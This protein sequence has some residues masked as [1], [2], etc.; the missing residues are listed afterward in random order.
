MS[1]KH[2]VA[3]FLLLPLLAFSSQT[4]SQKKSNQNSEQIISSSD[5]QL[6]S[7]DRLVMHVLRTMHS[8]E[9]AY[10][11]TYGVGNYGNFSALLN[12]DLI[13]PS[14]ASGEKYGYHF[15]VSTRA[16]TATMPPSFELKAVP[17][18]RRPR[19][20]SFYLN[21]AC[22]IRG[23][24][25]LGREATADDP[26]IEPCGASPRT[27]N[28]RASIASMRTIHGAE[29]TYAA[30]YGNSEYGTLAQLYDVDLVRTG[31]A[32]AYIWHGYSSTTTV[33]H[34]T[35]STPARFSISVVPTE[36]GRTGLR[37]FYLD[38]TG[39]LRGADKQ[40]QPADENDP[41]VEN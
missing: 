9:M 24:D 32:L 8:A 33:V 13:D 25:K 26:V 1:K 40:G 29:M 12:A 34:S 35:A 30:T 15:T 6:T 3:V 16:A 36:Y 19:K 37:S 39:V 31:F 17:A 38:E 10:S 11:A 41:P 27:E 18:L 28:E 21:E 22:E 7:N 23:A 20:L 4:F 2:L 5:V 14:Y